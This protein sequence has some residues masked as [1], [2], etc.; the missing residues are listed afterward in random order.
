MLGW[1]LCLAVSCACWILVCCTCSLSYLVYM[2]FSC[3]RFTCCL[4]VLVAIVL[5]CCIDL[6]V[7]GLFVGF[8]LGCL[9]CVVDCC[10]VV[11]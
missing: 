2:L 10:L 8:A 6:V 4:D 1:L 11:C 5:V 3:L 9:F 7:S